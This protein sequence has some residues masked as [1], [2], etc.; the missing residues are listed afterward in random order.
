MKHVRWPL[1]GFE[2]ISRLSTRKPRERAAQG[3]NFPS[4]YMRYWFAASVLRQ[5]H[6]SLGRPLKV[7]E[8]GVDRGDLLAFLG[9]PKVADDVFALPDWIERWDGFDVQ[10]DPAVVRRLSYS[11]RSEEHTSELQSRFG[12]SSA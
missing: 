9:G 11:N 1:E 2:N 5:L 6:A 4:R 7:L 3:T 12:I 8:V 10:F